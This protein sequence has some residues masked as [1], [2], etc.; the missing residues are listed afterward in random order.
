LI[1]LL[2][3]GLTIPSVKYWRSN[4]ETRTLDD[5]SRK[6]APGRF[7]TL[8]DGIVHYELSG[9]ANR[10]T[11]VLIHGFSVP[12]YLW[13]QT[14]SA[15]TGAGYRVLRYDLYGRGYSDRPDIAYDGASWEKQLHELLA[16]LGSR[17]RV[18]LVGASMGGSPA[19][20]PIR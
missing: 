8:S 5:D 6:A 7:I 20:S 16:A 13:D 15:L 17:G 12:Y 9:A 19:I 3:I 10:R 2:A 4:L 18:D 11:V 1:V 14:F